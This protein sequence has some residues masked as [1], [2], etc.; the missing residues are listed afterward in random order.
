MTSENPWQT[1]FIDLKPYL[2]TQ[3]QPI[4]QD[5]VWS[6]EFTESDPGIS[7]YGSDTGIDDYDWTQDELEADYFQE[8]QSYPDPPSTSTMLTPKAE[9]EM[10]NDRM[11]FEDIFEDDT[12]LDEA[13][14]RIR[15]K[16]ASIYH[17]APSFDQL[18]TFKPSHKA[19]KF[20]Y[21]QIVEHQDYGPP[22]KPSYNAPS[23][24]YDPPAPPAQPSYG[25]EQHLD[26]YE[27]SASSGHKGM[28]SCMPPV[29]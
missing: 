13:S 6:Q 20:G 5:I 28:T 8:R 10:S 9:E 29:K 12:I 7:D 17:H 27:A 16:K 3:Q 15:P 24:S 26:V 2:N 11:T 21:A 14:S 23:S 25:H 4:N 19:D 22:P 18:V 1:S